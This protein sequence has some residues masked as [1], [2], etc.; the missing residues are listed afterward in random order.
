[1]V[2][3]SATSGTVDTS[4]DRGVAVDAAVDTG[5]AVDKAVDTGVAVV[6]I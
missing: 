6:D 4:V 5:V 3:R 1:M 2:E